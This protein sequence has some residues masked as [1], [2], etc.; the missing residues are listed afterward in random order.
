[1]TETLDRLIT[2][3]GGADAWRR[4]RTIS[5]HHHFGGVLWK[6]KGVEGLLEDARTTVRVQDQWTSQ[7]PFGPLGY[8]S[9]VTADRV[10]VETGD[11]EDEIVEELRNPRA[12]FTGHVL[13]TP[14]TPAQL[15][16]FSGYA[17]WTYLTEPWSLILPGVQTEEIGPWS[18]GGET[19]QRLR[20]TYPKTIATHSPVQTVYVDADGLL[21]RRDYEVDIAGGSPSVHYASRFETVSGLVLATHREIFV[22]DD[23]GHA[24][25]EPVIV[26]INLDRILV[27]QH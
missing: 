26:S 25:P 21:R 9:T 27:E 1:M 13:E 2:A 16:Y 12:T 4:T 19:W 10:L 3:H 5:A 14:W 8:W 20:V 22:R 7:A 11:D 15:A 17:M 24:V 23:A 18:E 6:V